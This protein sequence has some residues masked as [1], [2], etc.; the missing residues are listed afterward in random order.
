MRTAEQLCVQFYEP[1][2]CVVSCERW[3]QS[4]KFRQ[5]SCSGKCFIFLLWTLW[6]PH[7]VNVHSII[8]PNPVSH[9][10]QVP[11]RT[12][13]KTRPRGMRFHRKAG[14]LSYQHCHLRKL[15]Y[16]QFSI[17]NRQRCTQS[18]EEKG[19]KSILPL[20]HHQGG[21]PANVSPKNVLTVWGNL[22]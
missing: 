1:P 22:G 6:P 5:F 17:C 21:R 19:P 15:H 8:L 11:K 16:M 2:M 7:F 9:S 3:R 12:G 14:K 13:V 4:E 20:P 18:S 10:G